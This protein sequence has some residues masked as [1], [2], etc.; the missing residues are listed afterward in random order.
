[1]LSPL[2]C[3]RACECES[4]SK[5]KPDLTREKNNKTV[6]REPSIPYPNRVV[7]FFI[8]VDALL[9]LFYS[10]LGVSERPPKPL[11]HHSKQSLIR[12]ARIQ[13]HSKCNNIRPCETRFFIVLG[14]SG[15]GE[16]DGDDGD[17]QPEGESLCAGDRWPGPRGRPFSNLPARRRW[18][19]SRRPGTC[20][21]PC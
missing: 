19:P 6:C 13:R 21:C 10:C 9:S 17:G 14:V 3:V 8:L 4:R 18:S 5:L 11:C 1:M 16:G 2:P 12:L 7:N 20:T 15:C